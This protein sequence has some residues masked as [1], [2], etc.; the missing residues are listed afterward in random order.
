MIIMCYYN[1][2]TALSISTKVKNCLFNENFPHKYCNIPESLLSCTENKS[3][4]Q[5][6]L[7]GFRCGIDTMFLNAIRFNIEGK[8]FMQ[9]LTVET[10]LSL[11]LNM[12]IYFPRLVVEFWL[13]NEQSCILV[14]LLNL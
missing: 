7:A 2:T 12:S 5:L 11:V 14:I 6:K 10:H 1:I 9:A 8:A 13:C 4:A 3:C